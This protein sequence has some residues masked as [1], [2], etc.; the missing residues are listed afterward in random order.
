MKVLGDIADH[1]KLVHRMARA[2]GVD[3]G[4]AMMDGQLDQQDWSQMVTNCRGCSC[5][6]ACTGWLQQAE[7]QGEDHATAP[8][9]C[10]NR[11]SF[12]LLARRPA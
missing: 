12:D 9:Y 11:A 6:G 5:P 8:D 2:T 7:L 3:L 10:E 4:E 1:L